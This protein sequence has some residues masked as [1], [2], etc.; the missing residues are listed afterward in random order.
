MATPASEN[1]DH[2]RLV[3]RYK[4]LRKIVWKLQNEALP[5]YLSKQAMQTSGE[6]LGIMQQG[7]LVFETEDEAAVLMDYAL[8]DYWGQG[9]NAILRHI[10]ACPPDPATEE[11]A[12]LKAMAEAFHTLVQVTEVLPGVGVCVV[13][14][15]AGRRE[16][17]LMDL[18]FG[19]TARKDLVLA[20]RLLPL[21]DFVMTSG[22]ALFV[23][24]GT[25]REIHDSVLTKY[26]TEEEGQCLLLG[27]RRKAADLTAAIIRLCLRS[28]SAGELEYQDIRR[29]PNI[30][31]L[32]EKARV[33]R[34]E[35]CPC[36]SGRKFKHC[37]GRG[38]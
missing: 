35:P 16:Y 17:L 31:P 18:G 24:A 9:A 2:A 26:G 36:G 20:A 23:D 38:R 27:G 1:A 28:K 30:T 19:Q 33:G 10:A 34:S 37:C 21:D 15:L 25:L 3:G 8:Y 7:T 4:D 12:A 13:D 22:A 11:Y 29:E 6:K 14:L 5:E 32:R